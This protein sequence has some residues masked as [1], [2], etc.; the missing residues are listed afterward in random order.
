MFYEV[1]MEKRADANEMLPSIRG[2]VGRYILGGALAGGAIGRKSADE[3]HKTR[4]MLLGATAGGFLGAGA[5][6]LHKALNAHRMKSKGY[7]ARFEYDGELPAFKDG[8]HVNEFLRETPV[9]KLRSSLGKFEGTHGDDFR[10]HY[11]HT[12]KGRTPLPVDDLTPPL[13]REALIKN[14]D[15]ISFDT[16]GDHIRTDSWKKEKIDLIRNRELLRGGRNLAL[17]A[18]AG[19][20]LAK[21]RKRDKEGRS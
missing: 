7:N 17:G 19:L 10:F 12:P 2:P 18:G 13:T 6:R 14:K 3:D 8:D 11:G 5:S 1:L 16:P 9:S 21:L 4:D 15:I 20:G